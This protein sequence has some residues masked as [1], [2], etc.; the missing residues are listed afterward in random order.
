MHE[1]RARN[2]TW[3]G[4]VEHI[5]KSVW[6]GDQ[7]L[8]AL[9]SEKICGFEKEIGTGIS[10]KQCLRAAGVAVTNRKGQKVGLRSSPQ[11]LWGGLALSHILLQTS[12]V[13]SPHSVLASPKPSDRA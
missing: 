12:Q 9:M 6:V 1:G 11:S 4:G 13:I 3:G 5:G 2:Q 8:R 10:E 7:R